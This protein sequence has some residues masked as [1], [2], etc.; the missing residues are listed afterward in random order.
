MVLYGDSRLPARFWEKTEPC[1]TSGCWHWT[2]AAHGQGYGK[3]RW[4]QPNPSRA[5]RVSYTELVGKIPHGLCLDHLC[6]NPGCVNPAH[7]E[8]VTV[9]ENTMR[10]LLPHVTK[11]RNR[12]RTSCRKGHE[13]SK[14]NTYTYPSGNRKCRVCEQEAYHARK[15]GR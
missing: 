1:P 6:R 11:A 4:D 9:R 8:P 3:F 13:V 7:L 12:D 14:A 5:H 2:G 10:G 15:K